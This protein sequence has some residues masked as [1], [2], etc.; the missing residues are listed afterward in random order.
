VSEFV[1]CPLMAIAKGGTDVSNW[2]CQKHEC[3]WWV[4][5]QDRCAIKDMALTESHYGGGRV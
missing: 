2:L 4:E 1:I 5:S 3:A